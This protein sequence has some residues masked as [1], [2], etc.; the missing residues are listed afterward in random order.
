MNQRQLRSLLVDLSCRDVDELGT[1]HHRIRAEHLNRVELAV[2]RRD[3]HIIERDSACLSC[4]QSRAKHTNREIHA[5]R[6]A[7]VVIATALILPSQR[8]HVIR[9]E[10][11]ACGELNANRIRAV[12]KARRVKEHRKRQ[13]HSSTAIICTSQSATMQ[14]AS[15]LLIVSHGAGAR[16][17]QLCCGTDLNEE[18]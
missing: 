3:P 15:S 8:E 11:A 1:E 17:A 16:F 10:R 4:K 9:I 13:S 12:V 18:H 14:H 2:A 6:P 7:T 5:L